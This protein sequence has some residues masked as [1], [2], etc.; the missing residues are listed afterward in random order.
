MTWGFTVVDLGGNLVTH[1]RMDGAWIGSVDISKNK[2]CTARAFDIATD[3]LK[4]AG[5]FALEHRDE[6]YRSPGYLA[7]CWDALVTRIG[8]RL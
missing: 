4:S 3:E 7:L 2:A 5:L 1:I 6:R 8:V